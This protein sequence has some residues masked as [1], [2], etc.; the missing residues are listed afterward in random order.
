MFYVLEKKAQKHKHHNR[1]FSVLDK[2][3]FY[4]FHLR[5]FM[6]V[7]H[8]PSILSK[9]YVML[10]LPVLCIRQNVIWRFK[11]QDNQILLFFFLYGTNGYK[12]K[13]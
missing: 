11:L 8:M 10:S 3:S 5:L 7:A 12:R 4:G 2:E 13:Q 6:T 9:F 1:K